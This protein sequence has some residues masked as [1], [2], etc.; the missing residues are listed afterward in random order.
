MHRSSR[1][2]RRPNLRVEQDSPLSRPTTWR[3]GGPADFLVRVGNA[4]DLVAAVRWA[5]DEGLPVT[6]IGGGTNLLVGDSGIRGLVIVSKVPASGRRVCRLAGPRRRGAL[7]VGAQAP[8]SWVGRF[9]SEHGWA[10][11]DWG[12]G[13]PGTIGGATVNNAGA[14]GTEQKDHLESLRVLRLDGAI[15]THDRAWLNPTY[16]NTTIK[17]MPR[18]RDYVVLD[19]MMRLPKGD[20][21]ELVRLA[22]EHAAYR[23]ATQPTGACAGSTFANPDGDFAGRL[24]EVAGLKGYAVGPVSFSAKHS[25]FII[26]AGG[27]TAGQVR[28]LIAHGQAASGT[29]SASICTARSNTSARWQGRNDQEQA[30]SQRSGALRR[31]IRRARCL[32]AIRPDGD[33]GLDPPSTRFARSASRAKAAGLRRRSDGRADGFVAALPARRGNAPPSEVQAEPGLPTLARDTVDV[34]FPVLHGPMG[35]DGTVQGML[36]LAGIPYVGSGVLG[37]A[38][39]MDKAM[40]KMVLSRPASRRRTG[41]W[42]TGPIGRPIRTRRGTIAADLG[43]PV[44]SSPPTWARASASPRC[45][46]KRTAPRSMLPEYDRR[47]VVE[48]GIDG[49]ELEI[50]VLGNDEPIASVAGEIVPCNE[51][52]DYNAKYVDD[53]SELIIP[54][55]LSPDKL[56]EMQ[57]IAIRAFRALDLAGMARVDFFLERGTERLLLNEVN[58][59][60]GFTSISMYPM[61][62]EASG[63]PCPNWSIVWSI[64]RSSGTAVRGG[65]SDA[66][67]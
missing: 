25:N 60:P 31:A 32:A 61:L 56:A 26:N 49:R 45:T 41:C 46:T 57:Q 16:R 2:P 55:D 8:L 62:W 29:G 66:E 4:D 37:S 44:S 13:L 1:S 19:V 43:F 27:G 33:P 47:I 21:A 10:G 54:A 63:V 7:T 3:I 67:I 18:P 52:Y 9:A 40:A 20:T 65:S 50:S 28:E 11:M 22:D 59:I 64:W 51:F 15:E 58:T 38:V 53:D 34:V 42:S 35:E 5:R 30:E 14:H 36:E 23:K 48:E 12:V 24:L 39:A 17:A 6:V